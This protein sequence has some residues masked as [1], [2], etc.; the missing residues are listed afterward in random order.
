MLYLMALFKIYQNIRATPHHKVSLTRRVEMS[1]SK[2]TFW[3]MSWEMNISEQN[4]SFDLINFLPRL[5]EI[6]MYLTFI[7]LVEMLI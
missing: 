7:L 2:Q 6:V 5:L 4:T 1:R 3:R